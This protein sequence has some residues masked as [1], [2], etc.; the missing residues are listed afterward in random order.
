MHLQINFAF[1]REPT[2]SLQGVSAVQKCLGI[3]GRQR[4]RRLQLGGHASYSALALRT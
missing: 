1:L 3:G 4:R 2:F